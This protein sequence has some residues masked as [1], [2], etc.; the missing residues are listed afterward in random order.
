MSGPNRSPDDV[1]NHSLSAD[2]RPSPA[3]AEWLSQRRHAVL[4][5]AR[6]DGTAQSSNVA[7]RYWPRE[8]CFRVSVTDGRAKTRNLRRSPM[9]TVHVLGP[10]FGS[11]LSVAAHAQLGVVTATAGDETSRQLLSVYEAITGTAHP[12]STAFYQA[13]VAERR[14]L[15][16][17]HPHSWSGWGTPD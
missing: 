11:Y 3:R 9:A 6:K 13:M 15:L 1:E 2:A 4:I 12:D 8:N 7:M 5:T 16:T 10:D 17:L 14:L